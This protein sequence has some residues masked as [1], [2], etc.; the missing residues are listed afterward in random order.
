MLR[1]L[2]GYE[3]PLNDFDKRCYD[4][5]VGGKDHYIGLLEDAL[6]PSCESEQLEEYDA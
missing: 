4:S 6:C 1:C 2:C 5:A 3:I